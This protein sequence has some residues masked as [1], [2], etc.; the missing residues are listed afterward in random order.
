MDSTKNVVY[1][2]SFDTDMN[3]FDN[4]DSLSKLHSFGKFGDSVDT[5]NKIPVL[6]DLDDAKNIANKMLE[7]TYKKGSFGDTKKYPVFGLIIVELI[8]DSIEI[9]HVE[10]RKRDSDDIITGKINYHN[11]S[12]YDDNTLLVYFVP[13]K[14]SSDIGSQVKRG[15]LNNKVF[16][17]HAKP[18]RYMYVINNNNISEQLGF[19]LLNK[20]ELSSQN[21]LLLKEI[22][23]NKGQFVN[24]HT[25]E[26]H[27]KSNNYE[28]SLIPS[29]GGSKYSP[30][31][32]YKTLYLNE[33]K[34]YI[35]LKNRA[36]VNGLL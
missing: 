19:Y 30:Y 21:I 1:Y 5:L 4:L 17:T 31:V 34:K 33:K 3:A 7:T 8:L 23:D 11:I 18:Q 15:V 16:L 32:D 22:Y 12:K 28:K 35:M 13:K 36:I 25:I 29:I 27:D 20:S 6:F 10:M 2:I 14:N 9:K 26:P 24:K